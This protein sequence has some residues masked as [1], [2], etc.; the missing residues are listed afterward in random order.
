MNY[1]NHFLQH[2]QEAAEMGFTQHF[3]MLPSGLAHCFSNGK[4]YLPEEVST[5]IKICIDCSMIF[6]FIKTI[7]GLAG[8]ANQNID[9]IH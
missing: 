8:T 9:E 2:L 3:K 7:D 4:R 6:Y 5:T 1:Y